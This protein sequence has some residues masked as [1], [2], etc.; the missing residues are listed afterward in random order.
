[1][2]PIRDGNSSN[3]ASLSPQV[4]DCPMPFALLYVVESQLGEFVATE[5]TCKQEGKQCPITLALQPLAVWRLPKC[6]PL[7]GGQPVAEPDAPPPPPKPCPPL[8]SWSSFRG[9]R[10]RSAPRRVKP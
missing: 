4:H 3:V 5:S 9:R 2:H 6:L 1:M 8:V 10:L 7:F